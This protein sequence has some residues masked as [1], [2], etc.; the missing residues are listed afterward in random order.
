MGS[1]GVMNWFSIS[2]KRV[3]GSYIF[4]H[5]NFTRESYLKMLIHL[6]FPLFRLLKEDY[7]S[8]QVTGSPPYSMR[9][10]TYLNNKHPNKWDRRWTRCLAGV[11][12]FQ[13]KDIFQ[14]HRPHGRAKTRTRAKICR[15]NQACWTKFWNNTKLRLDYIMEVDGSHIENVTE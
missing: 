5:E 6:A 12:F 14:N 1:P 3:I 8:L 11:G 7:V 9:V 2:N 15:I 10:T 13:I 4:E